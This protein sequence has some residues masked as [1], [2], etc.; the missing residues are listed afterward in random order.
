MKDGLCARCTFQLGHQDRL[1]GEGVIEADL[2]ERVPSA[3][4]YGAMV[5]SSS[6]SALAMEG[7]LERQELMGMPRQVPIGH[8]PQVSG[9]GFNQLATV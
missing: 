9:A 2:R 4:S 8:K 3:E 5:W 7:C 6:L 1:L